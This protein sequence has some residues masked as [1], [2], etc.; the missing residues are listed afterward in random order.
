LFI[1]DASSDE[2]GQNARTWVMMLSGENTETVVR[3]PNMRGVD[4]DK[5]IIEISGSDELTHGIKYGEFFAGPR[6]SDFNID[7][8]AT[9]Y[10]IDISRTL[11]D[12]F[13]LQSQP[14]ERQ[15]NWEHTMRFA[16]S[17]VETSGMTVDAITAR[18]FTIENAQYCVYDISGQAPA[19]L[20][21]SDNILPPGR[22]LTAEKSFAMNIGGI[23]LMNE[24]REVTYTDGSAIY[25]RNTETHAF[26]Y[27]GLERPRVIEPLRSADNTMLYA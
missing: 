16:I 6:I 27:V 10:A 5:G 18:A 17:L 11:I 9:V 20:L 8:S 26:T 24:G 25:V 15:L 14:F 4:R 1:C 3:G 19:T 7:I 12:R 13:T 2:F 23:R 22:S 21:Y